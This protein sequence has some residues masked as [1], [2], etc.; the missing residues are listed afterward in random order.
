ML[1]IVYLL[2]YKREFVSTVLE[3]KDVANSQTTSKSLPSG[4]ISKTNSASVRIHL[5][6][7]YYTRNH[8]MDFLKQLFLKKLRLKIIS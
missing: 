1:G 5:G 3:F 4:V 7:E 2:Y 6:T 8:Y